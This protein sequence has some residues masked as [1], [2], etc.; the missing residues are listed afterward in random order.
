VSTAHKLTATGVALCGRRF[1]WPWDTLHPDSAQVTCARCVTVLAAEVA[2]VLSNP[3]VKPAADGSMTCPDCNGR[4]DVYVPMIYVD[5]A[6]C[7]G[8][9]K[10]PV[11]LAP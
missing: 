11:T 4:G 2:F 3:G 6:R 10:V 8:T 9:G 1:L 7:S 5:C